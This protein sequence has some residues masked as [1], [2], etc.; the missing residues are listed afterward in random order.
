[1]NKKVTSEAYTMLNNVAMAAL[2]NPEFPVYFYMEAERAILRMLMSGQTSKDRMKQTLMD[3]WTFHKSVMEYDH[4]DQSLDRLFA[5]AER[6]LSGIDNEEVKALYLAILH[7]YDRE[8]RLEQMAKMK[9]ARHKG[10]NSPERYI[11]YGGYLW[12][13]RRRL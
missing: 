2:D 4:T 12:R 5:E 7:E 10:R 8:G 1:M 6:V 11:W 3:A 9:N 13:N